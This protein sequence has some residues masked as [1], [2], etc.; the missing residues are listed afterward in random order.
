MTP[1]ATHASMPDDRYRFNDFSLEKIRNRQEPRVAAAMRDLL[2]LAPDF[3]GCR[4]CVE[5]VYALSLNSLP[6]QYVQT[7]AMIVRQRM[8]S[9]DDIRKA[10]QDAL[11]VVRERPNHPE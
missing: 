5:D 9:D 4:L 1:L 3:C 6:A 2:P 10:V 8:P 7:G 11:D